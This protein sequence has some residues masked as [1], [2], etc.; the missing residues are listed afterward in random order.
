MLMDAIAAGPVARETQNEAL[1]VAPTDQ[2]LA[3]RGA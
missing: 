2:G 1:L 3:Q